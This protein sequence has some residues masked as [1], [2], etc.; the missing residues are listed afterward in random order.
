MVIWDIQHH[1][2]SGSREGDLGAQA[3]VDGDGRAETH[4]REALLTPAY[5][6]AATQTLMLRG[7]DSVLLAAGDYPARHRRAR[8]LAGIRTW[9]A[10]YMAC[11]LNAGGGDYG[12]ILHLPGAVRAERLARSL[13]AALSAELP[14]LAR[15]LVQPITGAWSRALPTVEGLAGADH[16]CPA[17][18]L[19]PA[20][21]DRPEHRPLLSWSGL[22]MVGGALARGYLNWLGSEPR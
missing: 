9:G 19:E 1:G 13:A 20:F 12:L 6:A 5:V 2:R 4:E 8:T 16:I 7:Q 14:Q 17:V 10:A 22:E 18:C 21:L 3:D 15:V 11:H